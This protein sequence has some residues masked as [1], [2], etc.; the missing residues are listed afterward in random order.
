MPMS[1]N[2]TYS[3]KDYWSLPDDKR[4]ELIDGQLYNMAPPGFIHQKLVFQIAKAISNYVDSLNGNCEVIPAPFA[5][6]LDANDNNW[7]EP[8]I[9]VICDKNKLTAR[10]CSGAPDLIVEVVSPSSQWHDCMRKLLLYQKHDVKEYW[11]VNPAASTVMVYN[12]AKDNF[13]AYSFDDKIPVG[14]YNNELS[15][16]ISELLK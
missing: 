8:D 11:I 15:I 13:T 1:L 7:V 5:V 10:G 14:I 2:K 4:A 12:F 6:N 16:C 3:S 9:S